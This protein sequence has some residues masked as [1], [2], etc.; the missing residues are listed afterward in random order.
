MRGKK[1]SL[2]FKRRQLSIFYSSEI[3]YNSKD[4]QIYCKYCNVKINTTFESGIK[5]HLKTLK[6]ELNK[7]V[8]LLSDKD[9][10]KE[11]SLE[12]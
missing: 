2:N 8:K 9:D 3:Y 6:H 11:N 5:R 7:K 1:S 12:K 10:I 4:F